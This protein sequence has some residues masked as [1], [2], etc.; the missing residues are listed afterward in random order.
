M[1]Q[2]FWSH[3]KCV[4]LKQKLLCSKSFNTS[5]CKRMLKLRS[6]V[7]SSAFE[8]K[9]NWISVQ[10]KQ[11]YWPCGSNTF[12]EDCFRKS[13]TWHSAHTVVIFFPQYESLIIKAWLS[14]D[15][16][17]CLESK[18]NKKLRSLVT[19]SACTLVH[20]S[21]SHMSMRWL[22]L[23]SRLLAPPLMQLLTS[24]CVPIESYSIF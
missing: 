17:S 1:F 10:Q 24:L 3:K 16:S 15:K 5:R 22:R 2:Y 18:E 20:F 13:L 7:S 23:F 19:V 11:K 14:F 8:L 12:R 4:E 9:P 6:I 21:S